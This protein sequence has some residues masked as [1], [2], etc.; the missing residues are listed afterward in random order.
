MARL[1]GNRTVTAAGTGNLMSFGCQGFKICNKTSI[2]AQAPASGGEALRNP[3]LSVFGWE[4]TNAGDKCRNN[5]QE[6][7]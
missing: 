5:P 6:E 2:S 4:E 3:L 1:R 7:R